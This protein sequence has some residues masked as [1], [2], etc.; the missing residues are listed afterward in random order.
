M[1]TASVTLSCCTFSCQKPSQWNGENAACSTVISCLQDSH[2]TAFAWTST[3]STIMGEV[4][5]MHFT[6]VDYVIFALLLVASA[7]I[8]LFYAFSGGRQRTTQV[9]TVNISLTFPHPSYPAVLILFFH[10]PQDCDLYSD[11]LLPPGVSDGR[12]LHDL[13][14][15]VPVLVGHF[16]VRRGHPGRSVRDLHLWDPVLVLG[17]L[18]L[19]GPA[20]TSSRV[21]TSLLQ[22]AAVQRL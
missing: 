22:A 1:I 7:G 19:S 5:Q 2:P 6:T 17:L 14:S 12:P 10:G 20:H 3:S 21:Y 13:P 11:L 4:V 9:R 15:C 8:G 16:P 18:L